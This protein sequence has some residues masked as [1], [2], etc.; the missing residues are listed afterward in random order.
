MLGPDGP[1]RDQESLLAPGQGEGM[2]DAQI[3]A[4]HPSRVGSR[5][6]LVGGHHHLGAHVDEELWPDVDQGDRAHRRGVVGD[7][8]G[9]AQLERWRA[10]GCRQGQPPTRE[11]KGPGVVARGHERLAAP[12]EMGSGIAVAPASGGTEPAVAVAAQDRSGP[13]AGQLPGAARAGPGQLRAQSLVGDDRGITAPESQG[14][15]LEDGRPQVTTRAEQSETAPSLG[16]G[17]PQ[18]HPGRPVE[19]LRSFSFP[20]HSPSMNRCCDIQRSQTSAT[21]RPAL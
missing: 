9:Q 14:V 8:A 4:A 21:A 5:S 10:P 7:V 17:H 18:L 13:R 1:S 20:W 16:R 6:L 3:H 19:N 12:W 2:D 15:E 11:H